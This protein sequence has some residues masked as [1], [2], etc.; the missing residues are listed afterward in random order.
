ME[1][2]TFSCFFT[3]RKGKK[4]KNGAVE[5]ERRESKLRMKESCKSGYGVSENEVRSAQSESEL[6][7]NDKEPDFVAVM[8][9]NIYTLPH[10]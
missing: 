6:L 10:R 9:E 2:S 3:G 8:R 5:Q 4:N 7:V 1:L